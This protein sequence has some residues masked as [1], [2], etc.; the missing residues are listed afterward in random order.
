MTLFSRLPIKGSFLRLFLTV[1][2]F[3]VIS[4]SLELMLLEYFPD[5]S[6][7]IILLV[8][9]VLISLFMLPVIYFLVYRPM[10]LLLNKRKT[11][12]TE[13]KKFEQTIRGIN[14]IVNIAD[15]DDKILF[16]NESF[17]KAYGYTEEEL[18]GK[19]SSIFWS[20]RNAK[21]VVDQILPETLRGGWKGELYNKRKDGTEFPISLSTS[22]IRNEQ[23]EH[24]AVVALVEDITEQK[25]AE[26][27][28]QIIFDITQGVTTTTN[29]YDLLKVIHE[30]LKRLI[31]AENCY[32]AIYNESTKLLSFPYF[33]D[34]YDAWP[35]PGPM[36]KGC[37][38][39]VYR[40]GK[41]FLFSKKVFAHLVEQQE[42]E[43]IGT[44]S[45]SW[46]G[47]PLHTPSGI[48]G[49]LV[50]QHYD[51]ENI[52]T[53]REVRFLQSVA[54]NIAMAIERQRAQ[55]ELRESEEMFR[56]LFDAS[57]DPILLLDDSGFT[58]CN[59]ATVSILGY[60]SKEEFLNK[61]PYEL[62]PEYQSDGLRSTD[63]SVDMM[64]RAIAAG[65]HRFEWTHLKADGTELYVEVML[66]PVV[67]KGKQYL[68]TIWRDIADRKRAEQA[69][70]ES[71]EHFRA[72]A[73]SANE[74]IIT[75]NSLGNILSWN[76]GA[77]KIFGYTEQ[78]IIGREL[79]TL[80]PQQYVE[81]HVS[82][83][84]R[85][86]DGP[87]RHVIGGTAELRGQ[88]K[89]GEEFPI[90]LSLAEWE[91]S[92]GRYFSAIIRDVTRRKL[93]EAEREQLIT[94]LQNA[95]EQIKTLK[96]IVP[97]CANC[98]KIRDDKGYWEQVDQY[99]AKHTDAKFSHGI[100]P[101]CTQKLYPDYYNRMS[102]DKEE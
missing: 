82:G 22:V 14:S 66:T 42:M 55:D 43:Q 102:K 80:I 41:P 16:V 31:Y 97:I 91:T 73:Q 6:H 35:E 84:K 85:G 2:S 7:R 64:K 44:V 13:A 83:M 8:N 40:T 75:S 38:S 93:I 29:L 12:E 4:R 9:G 72:V 51:E 68:Y 87:E 58:N 74:A 89:N 27:E 1:F 88:R 21:E 17:C 62:S 32:V 50:V 90:E 11:A 52:Y 48:I 92:T 33:V 28:R 47:V 3:I 54:S 37:T 24:I 25:R 46:L 86:A 99:V 26:L 60:R 19:H 95:I 39:Y 69:L 71:E 67:L 23:G 56:Q 57:A 78:E 36:N 63:K 101:D 100:C 53:D 20:D 18:I 15:L 10:L 65:Y 30:A 34:K 77:E 94:D 98:K 61:K 45:P 70:R 49:V 76:N 79:I 5:V 81:Q 96:G 59:S